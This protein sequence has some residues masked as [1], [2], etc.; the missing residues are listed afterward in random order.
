MAALWK[1]R[2]DTFRRSYLSR[3][4]SDLHIGH[5]LAINDV[6]AAFR[7]AEHAGKGELSHW[8]SDGIFW[9]EFRWMG[10]SY[11]LF[12]DA[13]GD[14]VD[15]ET[16]ETISFVVEVD[17]V[18]ELLSYVEA[19]ISKYLLLLKSKAFAAFQ[20]K[21]SFPVLVIITTGPAKT[22]S[23]EE[24]VIAGHERIELQCSA[25]LAFDLAGKQIILP[26][27]C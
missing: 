14:W 11:K 17:R 7:H 4:A 9:Y 15:S 26:R 20:G 6:L 27:G 16:R 1:E 21:P 2:A 5:R 23:L 19:K 25:R 3:V 24:R 12:P 18:T 10:R 8:E 13:R 22:K